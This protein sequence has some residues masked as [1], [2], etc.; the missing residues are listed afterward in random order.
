MKSHNSERRLRGC[1]LMCIINV[2][3]ET[4]AEKI[5]KNILCT[6][7]QFIIGMFF[8]YL[9]W[10]LVNFIVKLRVKVKDDSKVSGCA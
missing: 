7:I 1:Y 3:A 4:G 5:S 2:F 8:F 10:K 6:F 9:H